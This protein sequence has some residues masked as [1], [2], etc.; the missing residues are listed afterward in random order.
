MIHSADL[1]AAWRIFVVMPGFILYT[2]INPTRKIGEILPDEGESFC[3][4]RM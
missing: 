2:G 1:C 3:I 4:T